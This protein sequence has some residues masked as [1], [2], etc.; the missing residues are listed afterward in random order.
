MVLYTPTQRKKCLWDVLRLWE[1]QNLLRLPL[2]TAIVTYSCKSLSLSRLVICSHRLNLCVAGQY[3]LTNQLGW[4][5]LETWWNGLKLG[6]TEDARHTPY[7]FGGQTIA[8]RYHKVYI[9]EHVC[10]D[11]R[12]DSRAVSRQLT[13]TSVNRWR[14][15]WYRTESGTR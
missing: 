10:T 6:F 12:N 7:S 3:G 11:P 1:Y 2:I 5:L 8:I 13:C 15:L 14:H 9:F 4:R